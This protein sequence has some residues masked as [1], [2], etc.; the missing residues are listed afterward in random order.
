MNENETQQIQP[1]VQLM[2]NYSARSLPRNN[3]CPKCRKTTD[4]K[5]T[6]LENN[7]FAYYYQC[8]SCQKVK[9]T[10]G[11]MKASQELNKFCKINQVKGVTENLSAEV[12]AQPVE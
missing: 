7:K 2:I 12:Q 5:V 11:S 6:A 4:L 10:Q 8:G 1:D 9:H 3:V